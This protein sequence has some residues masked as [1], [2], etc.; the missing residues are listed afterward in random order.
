VT[1]VL[2]AE[3]R[4]HLAAADFGDKRRVL[5]TAARA[6][7]FTCAQLR[8]LMDA[9]DFAEDRVV[10]VQMIAPRVLDRDAYF[11]TVAALVGDSAE[12]ARVDEAWAASPSPSLPSGVTAEAVLAAAGATS[13]IDLTS[14]AGPAPAATTTASAGGG[15]P[16]DPRNRTD[17][18]FS[19]DEAF[20]T[21]APQGHR[22]NAHGEN[23]TPILVP[24]SAGPSFTQKQGPSQPS[25]LD[26]DL[27]PTPASSAA[28]ASVSGSSMSAGSTASA[29]SG[30]SVDAYAALRDR[31]V[32][33]PL[34]ANDLTG[35]FGGGDA[36][37]GGGSGGGGAGGGDGGGRS[38]VASQAGLSTNA[39]Q[40]PMEQRAFDDLMTTLRRSGFEDKSPHLRQ[41]AMFHFF[42]TTQLS[43]IMEAC[44]FENER[45]A[46]ASMIGPRLVDT[47][48]VFEVVSR[49]S[50]DT[51]RAKIAAVLTKL[52]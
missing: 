26:E 12:R 1:D 13:I 29:S 43:A 44:D 38:R 17:S 45:L 37:L 18:T 41:A 4:A 33:T 19:I 52:L 3:L 14:S 25:L 22:H 32:S 35:M 8:A 20:G 50:D 21:A 28:P 15:A 48:R 7:H 11:S 51:E 36:S 10:A 42:S 31:A 5:H 47:E 9:L 23:T 24:L 40:S 16:S 27:V 2:F 39:M 6:H 49:I 46:A 34:S 30:G